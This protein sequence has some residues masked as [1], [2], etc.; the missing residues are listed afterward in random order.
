M[1]RESRYFA[2]NEIGKT[3]NEPQQSDWHLLPWSQIDNFVFSLQS[4]IHIMALHGSKERLHQLQRFLVSS[5]ASKLFVVKKIGESKSAEYANCNRP[6]NTLNS[7]QKLALSLNIN[8]SSPS[9]PSDLTQEL[10]SFCEFASKQLLYLCLRPEWEAYSKNKS[11]FQLFDKGIRPLIRSIAH[12]LN[13]TAFTKRLYVSTVVVEQASLNVEMILSILSTADIFGPLLKK[14]LLGWPVEQA[15]FQA[16]DISRSRL[17]AKD[18]DQLLAHILLFHYE[19]GVLHTKKAYRYIQFYRYQNKIL[20]FSDSPDKL[21]DFFIETTNFFGSIGL[22]YNRKKTRILTKQQT[23]RFLGFEMIPKFLVI[24]GSIYSQAYL[25][26]SKEEKKFV[27]AKARYIL[28]SKHRDG[29]TRAKTNMPLSRAIAFINPL[30]INWN[31]YYVHLIPRE[32][33]EHLDWLL[34]EKVYRWYVKRLKKNRVTH[35]N[36]KCIQV[37][38]GKKRIAQDGY[39]LELFNDKDA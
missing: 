13:L 11:G 12:D 14:T 31:R 39:L 23:F 38:K 24:R 29:T 8:V 19:H 34:N 2:L 35:W 28:R 30:V 21:Q 6:F 16:T 27:L 33:F 20:I 25:N 5:Y 9:L 18:L 17:E 32:T 26:A 7:S 10:E 37:K 15:L 36:K 22:I 1:A 4:Q 3:L